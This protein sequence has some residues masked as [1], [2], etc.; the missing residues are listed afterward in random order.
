[1]YQRVVA[2]G[3]SFAAQSATS[4]AQLNGYHAA[5]WATFGFS[6]L[7]EFKFY[8]FSPFLVGLFF[9]PVVIKLRYWRYSPYEVTES[10]VA[11]LKNIKRN[12]VASRCNNVFRDINV[13][14]IVFD[15]FMDIQTFRS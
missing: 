9:A 4:V 11:T 10:S 12:R 13:V 8:V 7:G 15:I 1:M 6:M 14:D 5:Q 3:S 2:E